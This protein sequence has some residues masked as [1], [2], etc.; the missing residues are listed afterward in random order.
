MDPQME[1]ELILWL[2][3]F[4]RLNDR[5]PQPHLIKKMAKELSNYPDRFKASKGWY[6]RFMQR[7]NDSKV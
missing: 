4:R 7:A 3:R 1:E 5:E 2:V 6:E